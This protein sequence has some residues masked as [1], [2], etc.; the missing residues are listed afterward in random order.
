[1]GRKGPVSTCSLQPISRE[2]Q[3]KNLRLNL[4]AGTKSETTEKSYLLSCSL[5][6]LSSSSL[7]WS[8]ITCSGV[9]LPIV[10]LALPRQSLIKIM[11]PQTYVQ[12]NLREAIL[13]SRLPFPR[14]TKSTTKITCREYRQWLLQLRAPNSSIFLPQNNPKHESHMA[15]FPTA[16]S[17]G[18]M[19]P[20]RVHKLQR[21]MAADGNSKK[22]RGHIF[23]CKQDTERAH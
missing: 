10:C 17:L 2:S 16:T 20:E 21:D 11:S 14:C 9:A 1:M 8:K 7:V 15:T 18:L 19:V 22:L 3:G 5:C 23:T 4:E 13:Q 12:D 6:P